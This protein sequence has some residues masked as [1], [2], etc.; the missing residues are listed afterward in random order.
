MEKLTWVRRSASEWVS[1][2]GRFR[3][4]RDEDE[5]KGTVYHLYDGG[6]LFGPL[7]SFA[8]ASVEASATCQ[9]EG[10]FR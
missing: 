5:F 2:G 10:N 6:M 8:A 3:I 4:T 1:G 9:R 7:P